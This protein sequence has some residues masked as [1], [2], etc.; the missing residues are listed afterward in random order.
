MKSTMIHSVIHFVRRGG[1]FCSLAL[2][3]LLLVACVVPV[4]SHGDGRGGHDGRDG[5]DGHDYSRDD[6]RSRGDHDYNDRR[7]FYSCT[8][9]PEVRRSDSGNCPRCGMRL[10]RMREY[11]RDDRDGRGDRHDHDGGT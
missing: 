2:F 3:P 8:M 7:E 11:D 10:V 4:E 1:V 9:H 5:R 6:D